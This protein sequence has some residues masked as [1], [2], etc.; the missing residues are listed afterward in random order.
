MYISHGMP[1][2][3]HSFSD[4]KHCFTFRIYVT[5]DKD[6]HLYRY[7]VPIV[8]YNESPQELKSMHCKQFKSY[9][10]SFNWCVKHNMK[11]PD[12][13]LVSTIECVNKDINSW[14]A[15]L[16]ILRKHYYDY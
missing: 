1:I 10:S 5:D 12:S 13:K 11:L 6:N 2:I 15:S 8:Y 4:I 16:Y 3:Y 7:R 14:L 9:E